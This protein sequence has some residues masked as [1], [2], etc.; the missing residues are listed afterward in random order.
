MSFFAFE[1]ASSWV[2][3]RELVHSVGTW[4]SALELHRPPVTDW[5][6]R[7]WRSGV[8]F[9][10]DP[11]V[12][13]CKVGTQYWKA[14]D[15][16]CGVD[17]TDLRRLLELIT[18]LGSDGMR[19]LAADDLRLAPEWDV[20]PSRGPTLPFGRGPQAEQFARRLSDP[21]AAA[22]FLETGEDVFTEI[23]AERGQGQGEM[24]RELSVRRTGDEL[25]EPTDLEELVEACRRQLE[26]Q[27][28]R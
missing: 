17:A 10:H 2:M 25:T 4:R 27:D 16:V 7:A 23:A 3:R 19:E 14:A 8:T 20:P 6:L 18:S 12:T 22:R 24:L 9:H 21:E 28:G 1:P 15:K 26:A 11:V 5:L 13:V